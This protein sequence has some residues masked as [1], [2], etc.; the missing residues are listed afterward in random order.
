MNLYPYTDA[1]CALFSNRGVR[2]EV[3]FM[4][5]AS[6]PV[7]EWNRNI[8]NDDGGDKVPAIGYQEV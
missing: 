5:L 1:R 7:H 3:A 2:T 4:R 8:I 6:R